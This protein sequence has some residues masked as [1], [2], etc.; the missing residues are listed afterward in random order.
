[1]AW[2]KIRMRFLPIFTSNVLLPYEILRMALCVL[3]PSLHQLLFVE[4]FFFKITNLGTECIKFFISIVSSF[5]PNIL[6]LHLCADQHLLRSVQLSYER[7]Q[8]LFYAD[9]H[10]TTL[11]WVYCL[12]VLLRLSSWLL[13][14]VF[15]LFPCLL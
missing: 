5:L 14:Y 7:G 4:K 10:I 3:D 1:M 8:N 2:C 6:T 9:C 12:S 11:I 13:S 15:C